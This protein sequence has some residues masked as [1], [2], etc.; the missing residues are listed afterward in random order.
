M[1]KSSTFQ[2]DLFAAAL[3]LP[4]IERDL[5]LERVCGADR[6]LHAEVNR[7]LAAFDGAAPFI[8]EQPRATSL[9]SVG[10]QI[11]AYRLLQ[12]LGE[13]GCG[14]VYLAEQT[15]PVKREVALKV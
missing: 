11:G 6:S 1:K 9:E 10:D 2:E 8:R 14:V 12:E 13:G 5:Y 15:A 3:A 7:L 4:R